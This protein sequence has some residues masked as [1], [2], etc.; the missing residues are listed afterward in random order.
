MI[1]NEKKKN[2]ILYMKLNRCISY[3]VTTFVMVF[4]IFVIKKN[5]MADKIILKK[6]KHD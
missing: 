5:I 4:T 6:K 1:E 3:F 2:Y